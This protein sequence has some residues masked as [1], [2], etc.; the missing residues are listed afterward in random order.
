[1]ARK[2]IDLP[3]LFNLWHSP[4]TNE[5]ICKKLGITSKFLTRLAK[6][7]RL[8]NRRWL[9]ERDV[10]IKP[11]PSAAERSKRA[12]DIRRQWSVEE[13]LRRK[14]L[15]VPVTAKRHYDYDGKPLK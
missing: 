6:H 2:K 5:Q 11:I 15:V 13:R 14:S 7:H 4:L 10:V 1:M 9:V 12:A 8:G 3:L